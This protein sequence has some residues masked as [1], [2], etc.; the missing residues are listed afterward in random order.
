M[1]A[2]MTR[3]V[4]GSLGG[5]GSWLPKPGDSTPWN[6]ARPGAAYDTAEAASVETQ[7]RMVACPGFVASPT[8]S[9][10]RLAAHAA[11]AERP[12]FS[13]T[14]PSLTGSANEV[15]AAQL[16]FSGRFA[17]ARRALDGA[18]TVLDAWRAGSGGS[19]SASRVP[20]SRRLLR[21]LM[22][23]TRGGATAY[24]RVTLLTVPFPAA[25]FLARIVAFFLLFL[26]MPARS[27]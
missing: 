7:F 11:A 18:P 22:P 3:R 24:L 8:R 1:L 27:G 17:S 13:T 5:P 6:P 20:V 19:Q 12:P 15:V 4:K 14:V 26:V 9:E 21:S 23:P 2:V 16:A 25:A 10:P